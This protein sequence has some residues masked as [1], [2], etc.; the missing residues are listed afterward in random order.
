LLL[1]YGTYHFSP[2]RRA[3]RGDFCLR[4][5][6]AR[7]AEQIETF[8]F[9]H[10]FFVPILPLGRHR[11]WKC[12][13]CGSNPHERVRSTQVFKVLTAV[14]LGLFTLFGLAGVIVTLTTGGADDQETAS[15]IIGFTVAMAACCVAA[16]FWCRAKPSTSLKEQ[17][18]HVPTAPSDVC[19]YCG[20]GLDIL[21]FCYSCKVQ[22]LELPQTAQPGIVRW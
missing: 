21:G 10:V 11:R 20:G 22:R 19:V 5:D 2:K 13:V 12:S 9:L 15:F 1:V 6:A 7:L 17:L 18:P 8:D 16:I 14:F 4:C 3:Y